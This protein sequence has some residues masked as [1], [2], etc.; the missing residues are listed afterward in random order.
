[1]RLSEL[2]SVVTDA[3][4]TGDVG[5]SG[6]G[7]DSRIV[8]RGDL[9]VA[10]V[11]GKADGHDFVREASA[12]GAAAVMVQHPVKD[13]DIPQLVVADTRAALGKISALFFDYPSRR[14][15]VIGVTGTNGKTTTT[16]LI[17]S[18]LQA[19]G[20]RAG[21]IGTI[22][23]VTGEGETAALN[24]TPESLVMQRL[25]S[26]MADADCEYAVLEVSS[27]ALDAGRAD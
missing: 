15:T 21:L 10:L 24:T 2:Q 5:I 17:R 23:Y 11:G 27:H 26:E 19:A 14:L 12:A 16:Y 20:K 9:F 6:I 18:I 22:C 25:L 1:M 7:F 3:T 8:R 4:L 13:I